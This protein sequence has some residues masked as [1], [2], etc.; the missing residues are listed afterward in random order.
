MSDNLAD[1]FPHRVTVADA[2]TSN[3]FRAIIAGGVGSLVEFY[4]FGIY[5]YLAITTARLFFPQSTPSAALLANLAVFATAFLVRPIGSIIFGHIGDRMGRKPALVLSVILMALATFLIGLLPTTDAIGLLAP[6]LLVA[7]RLVQ[8]LSA[9]GEAGGAATLL[10]EASQD[11]NRGLMCSATQAG[12]LLGLLLSSGVVAILNA[13]LSQGDI[14]AWG[15]R[16]PFLLA[17]P[18]GL[19]GWYIRSKVEDSTAFSRIV[20]EGHVA[21][22]PF[23]ETFRT[24]LRPIL[25]TLGICV[26]DFIGYYLVFVYL[27]IY[28]QTS[29]HLTRSAA[30][31]STTATLVIAVIALP[32]FG[33]LSDRAGRR[34][35]IIGSSIAFL[36]LTLPMFSL[37]NSGSAA[38]AVLAQIILGLCVASIMGVL[39]AA[40]VELFPTAV[41]YSGM[42]FAFSLTAATVGG[43]T[44][45]V[46]TWLIDITGNKQAPAY[47]LMASALVTLCAALTLR[48]NAGRPLPD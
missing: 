17:L 44:P 6:V 29:G 31:W 26:M 2:A 37:I 33:A 5:G 1:A 45:Y 22:I 14:A 10:G 18:T 19:I 4:D 12:G 46:A 34:P 20:K 47:Y 35:V 11:H 16:I 3:S 24:S 43:T 27:S 23:V 8:G 9:G 48:E 38:M 32:L 39:W 25:Q 7:A 13:A 28:L 15:W 30:I 36:L 41:R 40:I 21:P 42:G